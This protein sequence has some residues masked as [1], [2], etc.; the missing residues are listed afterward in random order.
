MYIYIYIYIYICVY[1]YMYICIYIGRTDNADEW[2]ELQQCANIYK[3]TYICIY[4]YIYVYIYIYIYIH[5][6][7]YIYIWGEAN[8]CV[9]ILSIGSVWKR[10]PV[11]GG[12]YD[13]GLWSFVVIP[14]CWISFEKKSRL[15]WALLYTRPEKYM[16]I[17]I[18][19]GT[20][21]CYVYSRG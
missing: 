15:C 13:V 19:R 1:I 7:I 9:V 10:S 2:W 5:M 16:Y 3:C 18:Y 8:I 20:Y 6:Y 11:S 12:V 14:K 17:C 4:M 21:I